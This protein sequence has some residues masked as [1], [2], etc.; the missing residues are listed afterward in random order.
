MKPARPADEPPESRVPSHGDL[1]VVPGEFFL[2]RVDG[3]YVR[4]AAAP[5]NFRVKLDDGRRCTIT[6][7]GAAGDAP[8]GWFARRITGSGRVVG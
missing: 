8:G 3:I 5:N 6:W 4:E 1:V 2:R 7:K